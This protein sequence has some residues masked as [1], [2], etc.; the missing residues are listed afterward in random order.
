MPSRRPLWL[1][2]LLPFLM[3]SGSRAMMAHSQQPIDTSSEHYAH[4][5]TGADASDRLYAARVLHSRLRLAL[6]GARRGA[7]GSFRRDEALATLDDFDATVAPACTEALTF[8]NVAAH[9]A[10]MLGLLEHEE[11]RPALE[12]LL[13]PE[14]R[15]NGRLRRKA[16]RAIERIQTTGS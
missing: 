10:T 3:G 7:P 8:R 2:A 11:A 1:L 12:A 13:S 16:R 9:C 6:K 5:L 4:D 14:S 15:A